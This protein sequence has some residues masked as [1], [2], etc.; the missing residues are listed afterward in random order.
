MPEF[1]ATVRRVGDSMGIIIPHRVIEQ[2]QAHPG[3]KVRVVI[4]TKVDW[5]LVWGRLPRGSATEKLIQRA[6]TERD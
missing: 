2:V 5:S 1:G 6:R 4:P 3:Q